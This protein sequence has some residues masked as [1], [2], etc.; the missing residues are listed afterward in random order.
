MK[1]SDSS[2][3][4][5]IIVISDFKLGTSIANTES[6]SAGYSVDKETVA[7]A[8]TRFFQTLGKTVERKDSGRLEEENK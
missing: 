3:L 8:Y 5:M 2:G 7:L 6:W 1:I 4:S